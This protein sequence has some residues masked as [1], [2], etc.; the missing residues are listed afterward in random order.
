M[1][2]S[3][4]KTVIENTPLSLEMKQIVC[5]YKGVNKDQAE[6]ELKRLLNIWATHPRVWTFSFE[7]DCYNEIELLGYIEP[8]LHMF[9]DY[10][11]WEDFEGKEPD[12][13]LT[14]KRQA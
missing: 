10:F 6:L 13:T 8:G 11:M 12:V 7:H 1:N 9:Q 4:L 14:W 5:F 2:F 3:I